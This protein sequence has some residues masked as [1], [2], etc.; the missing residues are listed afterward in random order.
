MQLA[1][2]RILYPSPGPSEAVSEPRLNIAVIFTSVDA[3]L[4]ALR[5]AGGLAGGWSAQITIVVPQVVPYPLPLASPPVRVD[6]NERRLHEIAAR[7]PVETTVSVYLCR[8]REETLVSVLKP[9]TVVVLG[10]KKRWWPTAEG[11]LARLLERAGHE[12]LFAR[13]E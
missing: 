9:G 13:T 5:M 12:V 10:G 6:F 8:D 1:M 3:T 11:R 2:E 4:A 7:S